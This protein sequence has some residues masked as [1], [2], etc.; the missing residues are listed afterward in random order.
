MIDFINENPVC[1]L[2]TA[3][4]DQPRVRAFMCWLADE[5]GIYFDTADYKPTFNQLQANPR[6]EAC[7]HAGKRMLRV[8]GEAEFTDDPGLRKKLFGEKEDDPHTVIFRLKSGSAIYWWKE[9]GK[10]HKER[11]E[12]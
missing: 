11:F 12:F 6:M 7:F 3:D 9:D 2:A 5:S 10:S 8:S 1:Y 4:G